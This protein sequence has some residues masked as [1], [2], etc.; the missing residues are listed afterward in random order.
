MV[1]RSVEVAS[2][3]GEARS[4]KPAR[5]ADWINSIAVL[6]RSMKVRP[7]LVPPARA[8]GR[9]TPP[10]GISANFPVF[11]SE[12][13]CPVFIRSTDNELPSREEEDRLRKQRGVST[14]EGLT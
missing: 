3:E 1:I 7:P 2:R 9:F 11:Q 10:P 5:I 14:L 4:P 6:Q 13:G 12:G 8:G